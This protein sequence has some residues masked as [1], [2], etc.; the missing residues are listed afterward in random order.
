MET[1]SHAICLL[2]FHLDFNHI[3]LENASELTATE[4]EMFSTYIPRGSSPVGQAVQLFYKATSLHIEKDNW[5]RFHTTE[6]PELVMH[7]YTTVC[8][9]FKAHS[10]RAHLSLSVLRLVEVKGWVVPDALYPIADKDCASDVGCISTVRES[11]YLISM[12][13]AAAQEKWGT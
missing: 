7:F 1:K 9:I 13:R 3:L 6:D 11:Q 5:E 8:D 12:A 2:P 10:M 4:A